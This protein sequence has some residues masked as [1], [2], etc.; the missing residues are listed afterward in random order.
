M[1]VIIVGAG[2]GGLATALALQQVGI[3]NVVCLE[4]AREL[5]PL[6]VGINLLPHAVREL[7]E[8]GLADELER[9]G[10]ATA[11]LTYVNEYGSTIWSEA[12]GLYAGYRWPQYSIHRGHFQVMLA[13]H[14]TA[15]LGVDA[16]RLGARVQSVE[17]N[18]TGATV[19]WSDD[20]GEH[21]EQADVVIAADGIRSAV[22]AQLHPHEGSPIPNG[23]I[24]WRG[25]TRTRPFL[26]GRSMIMAGYRTQRF[27]AYPIGPV[28]EDGLQ[29]INWIAEIA[30]DNRIIGDSD[31][32][33][34]V[35]VSDFLTG[36]SEWDLGWLNVPELINGADFVFEYPLVDRNPLDQWVHGRL[37]LLGDAAH[38]TY[39]VGSNGSSQAIIDA[40]VIA[41]ALST[42]NIDAALAYYENERL[43]KTRGLQL[44]NRLMGP[45]IVMQMA[46]ER[47]PEG[48]TDIEDVIPRQELE[49]VA[50]QYKT[51]AGFDPRTLNTR[52]AWSTEVHPA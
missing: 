50:V 21:H 40:R 24:L 14:V 41:F 8:L 45:E 1:R 51:L 3:T 2:I 22:R 33:K 17:Y 4:A 48:F 10:V 11:D 27:V 43:P 46:H 39:P 12:C 42:L 44:A 36:F 31:W 47:A 6:G 13:E 28:G 37:V 26:S 25:V 18:S 32:N 49:Q 15:R 5:R 20:S 16:V 35:P 9:I 7:T 19:H 52:P 29:D 30:D 38:P 23:T 34:Q